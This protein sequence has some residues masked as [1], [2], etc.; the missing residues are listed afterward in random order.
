MT[1]GREMSKR[2]EKCRS[3][4]RVVIDEEVGEFEVEVGVV[5]KGVENVNRKGREMSSER[6]VTCQKG[7]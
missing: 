5:N 2:S 7:A 4:Y 1:K 6:S 3:R